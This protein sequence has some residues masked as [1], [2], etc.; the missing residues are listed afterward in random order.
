MPVP[1]DFSEIGGV[2]ERESLSSSP[3]YFTTELTENTEVR[4]EVG[5]PHTPIKN[6][7]FFPGVQ[8]HPLPLP[9]LGVLCELGGG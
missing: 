2:V 4:A 9:H 3:H 6:K 8:G 5:K 1:H 7:K